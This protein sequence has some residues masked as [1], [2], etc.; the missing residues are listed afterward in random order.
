MFESRSF[1]I[2]KCKRK[3]SWLPAYD[4]QF[5]RSLESW[6][7]VIH[8]C[9]WAAGQAIIEV[10]I[11][12]MSHEGTVQPLAACHF[13]YVVDR[14]LKFDALMSLLKKFTGFSNPSMIGPISLVRHK[15]KIL[16]TNCEK[17]YFSDFLKITTCLILNHNS[18]FGCR[19]RALL[20]VFI[21]LLLTALKIWVHYLKHLSYQRSTQ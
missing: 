2:L 15:C 17:I 20:I 5:M 16:L 12:S 6:N 21:I 13:L 3:F 4:L 19:N 7:W 10:Q 1:F 9:G 11:P 14:F 8:H 18:Y